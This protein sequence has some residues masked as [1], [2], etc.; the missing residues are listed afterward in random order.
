MKRIKPAAGQESVWDY[1]RP[2]LIEPTS[3]RVRIEHRGQVIADSSRA[4]R[5]CETSHP[6]VYF[7]PP[8]DVTAGVL[9]RASGTSHCEWKGEAAYW[10]VVVDDHIVRRVAWSYPTPTE[11]AAGIAGYVAFYAG[12]LEECRVDDEVVTPQPGDFYGGWVTKDI[13]GPF[14]GAPGTWG[15]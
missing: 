12:R 15:W 4:W 5:V 7:V 9:R 11:A 13:V 14:K 2:P 1:P 3:R 8:D 6:P 10:D